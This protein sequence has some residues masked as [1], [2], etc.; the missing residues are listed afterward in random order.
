MFRTAVL[1]KAYRADM[2]EFLCETGYLNLPEN[3]ELA[4]LGKMQ[5]V[6]IISSVMAGKW[7]EANDA[8]QPGDADDWTDTDV[9]GPHVYC[10]R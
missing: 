6:P 7:G 8:F 2:Q 1:L 5:Q 3:V 10:I 9:K 4:H